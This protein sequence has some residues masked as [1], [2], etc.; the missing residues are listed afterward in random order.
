[1]VLI[2]HE[3]TFNNLTGS[4]RSCA[5]KAYA[6]IE[7]STLHHVDNIKFHKSSFT[8]SQVDSCAQMY[9]QVTTA[10]LISG[11]LAYE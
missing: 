6:R 3:H 10:V 4:R 1:M 11:I 2:N 5:F 8:S 7:P 9:T